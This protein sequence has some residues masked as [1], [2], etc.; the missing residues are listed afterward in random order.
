MATTEIQDWISG[1]DVPR[2]MI[3]VFVID[4]IEDV[5]S[6]YVSG[7]ISTSHKIGDHL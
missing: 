6:P 4:W 2:Y 3:K 1:L 7:H 5:E